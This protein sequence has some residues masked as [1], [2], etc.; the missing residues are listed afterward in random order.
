MKYLTAHSFGLECLVVN[1]N[2]IKPYYT[3][4]IHKKIKVDFDRK[5]NIN[6]QQTT[7]Y[8]MHINKTSKIA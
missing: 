5:R 4:T 7:L 6:N 3:T 8:K 2:G 1:R